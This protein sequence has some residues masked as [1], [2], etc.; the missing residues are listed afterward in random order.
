MSSEDLSRRNVS[1]VSQSLPVKK[2]NKNNLFASSEFFQRLNETKR[3]NP[4]RKPFREVNDYINQRYFFYTYIYGLFFIIGGVA[5][6]S[7]TKI[8]Y[9]LLMGLLV[10]FLFLF[11]AVGHT[12]DYYR[13]V[14]LQ[15]IYL[16][17]PFSKLFLCSFLLQ[18]CE[19]QPIFLLF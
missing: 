6:Y 17:I 13:G 3:N 8:K 1:T 5:G 11:V 9:C 16:T 4:R 19:L 7:K 12:I 15:V 2:N 10:G 14:R 18:P